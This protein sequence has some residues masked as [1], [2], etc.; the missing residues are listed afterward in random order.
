ML[1]EDDSEGRRMLIW[2]TT[3]LSTTLGATLIRSISYRHDYAGLIVTIV[4][5]STEAQQDE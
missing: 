3:T 2:L 4:R 1:A 5:D